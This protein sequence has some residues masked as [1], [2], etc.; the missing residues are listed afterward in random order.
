MIWEDRRLVVMAS[1]FKMSVRRSRAMLNLS[2]VG[3]FDGTSAHELL[4][5]LA[6]RCHGL[7]K[8]VIDTEGLQKVYPFGVDTFQKNLH[9][10]KVAPC[11]LE[12]IGKNATAIAPDG[13]RFLPVMVHDQPKSA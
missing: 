5:V 8:A 11:G 6:E 4:H 9:T 2:L 1:N 13:K 10:L 3:D 7:G 12:F